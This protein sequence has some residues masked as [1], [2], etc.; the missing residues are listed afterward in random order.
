MSGGT[1]WRC[2]PNSRE[3]AASGKMP[4]SPWAQTI[5]WS[6]VC[7]KRGRRQ[8]CQPTSASP[9]ALARTRQPL[10]RRQREQQP[11]AQDMHLHGPGVVR[12]RMAQLPRVLGFLETTGFDE[13]ALVI[14]INGLQ[15]LGHRRVGQEDRWASRSV[16]LA[17]P[18]PPHHG[19]D[20]VGLAVAALLRSAM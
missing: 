14:G 3:Y 6:R 5:T 8:R 2:T 11:R 18:L 9:L 20:A 12:W 10:R 15:Q 7:A 4:S 19:I 16:V 1:S 13:A 17:A